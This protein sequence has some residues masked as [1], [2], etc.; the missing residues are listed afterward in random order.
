ML[1]QERYVVVKETARTADKARWILVKH[2][3]DFIDTVLLTERTRH[4]T[5]GRALAL[6]RELGSLPALPCL[7]HTTHYVRTLAARTKR[8]KKGVQERARMIQ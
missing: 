8:S 4:M 5:D 1:L 3:R 6:P 7:L 2:R